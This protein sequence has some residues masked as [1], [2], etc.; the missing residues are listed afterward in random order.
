MRLGVCWRVR[1]RVWLL[2]L[3]KPVTLC[4]L[5]YASY[6]VSAYFSTSLDKL[7]RKCYVVA[8]LGYI[9]V[10]RFVVFCCVVTGALWCQIKVMNLRS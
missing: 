6:T 4:Q 8:R 3:I 9:C 5:H 1:L 2:N 7:Y 10:L